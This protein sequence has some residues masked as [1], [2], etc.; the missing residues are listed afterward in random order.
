MKHILIIPFCLLLG[1]VKAQDKSSLVNQIIKTF[2]DST[3]NVKVKTNGD[4]SYYSY[5][6]R[7]KVK[8][9]KRRY[10]IY[11]FTIRPYSKLPYLYVLFYNNKC[12]SDNIFLGYKSLLDDLIELNRLY[13]NGNFEKRLY[14][15]IYYYLIENYDPNVNG[16]KIPRGL[17]EDK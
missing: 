10:S 2:V 14:S 9:N 15:E 1:F 3:E 13:I 16:R 5:V 6:Y 7:G 12:P 11:I 8:Y 17:L 4:L